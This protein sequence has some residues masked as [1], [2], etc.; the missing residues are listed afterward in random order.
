MVKKQL[1]PQPLQVPRVI[2]SN[3]AYLAR[4]KTAVQAE[5]H[6]YIDVVRTDRAKR[7]PSY[8]NRIL[9]GERAYRD[10]QR[11]KSPRSKT[12]DTLTG[13]FYGDGQFNTASCDTMMDTWV[14]PNGRNNDELVGV[15][16]D[17]EI[18][19]ANHTG[20]GIGV[21][22]EAIK[23]GD[24]E[25]ALTVLNARPEV[26]GDEPTMTLITDYLGTL[27]AMPNF[28]TEVLPQLCHS[29]NRNG[30]NLLNILD[31][32][33]VRSY[34]R[35]DGHLRKYQ[36]SKQK[37]RAAGRV[38]TDLPIQNT[39][40]SQVTGERIDDAI[41]NNG[42]YGNV[43]RGVF[44]PTW[45]K[46]TIGKSQSV[47]MAL[48]D[49]MNSD[50]GKSLPDNIREVL[51]YELLAVTIEDMSVL[52]NGDAPTIGRSDAKMIVKQIAQFDNNTFSGDVLTKQIEL[53]KKRDL[54]TGEFVE[55]SVA[56][57]RREKPL[58]VEEKVIKM[59]DEIA[60][61][62][63]I[64]SI[65]PEIK[66]ATEDNS[67]LAGQLRDEKVKIFLDKC[68]RNNAVTYF[69][70]EL[71]PKVLEIIQT[72][73]REAKDILPEPEG[74]G[75]KYSREQVKATN[76]EINVAMNANNG[77]MTQKMRNNDVEALKKWTRLRVHKAYATA[78]QS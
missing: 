62:P 20:F 39:I 56:E 4:E 38:G 49:F 29:E 23:H 50:Y 51:N 52:M 66:V 69:D 65:L 32:D 18:A 7:K 57:I 48:I 43:D 1:E 37:D 53:W 31:N 40:V 22:G 42:G 17:G 3:S 9:L 12:T 26:L 73:W 34:V 8:N 27:M 74:K 78:N 77:E 63:I 67:E 25:M 47:G 55:K 76:D 45:N 13:E 10:Y 14:R 58:D 46:V 21:I 35:L 72:A 64:D 41:R 70:G 2:E 24:V 54:K 11:S 28:V 61:T 44:F 36:E 15:R 19:L 75:G 33:T 16:Q 59:D 60:V 30:R 5:V 71:P 6:G 68:V